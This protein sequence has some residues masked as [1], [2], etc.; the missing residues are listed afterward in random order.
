[1][2]AFF[3]FVLL[4]CLQFLCC[5]YMERLGFISWVYIFFF[6]EIHHF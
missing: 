5:S 3:F 1:M 4:Q 2:G 6:A